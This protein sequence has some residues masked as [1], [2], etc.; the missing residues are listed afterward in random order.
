MLAI[1]TQLCV[2]AVNI[3]QAN[4]GPDVWLQLLEYCATDPD[5]QPTALRS[6]AQQLAEQRAFSAQRLAKQRVVNT[7]LQ[8]QVLD[9]QQHIAGLQKQMQELHAVVHQLLP[10]CQQ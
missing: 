8:R 1:V 6:L 2:F 5:C 7:R 9:Q 3:L 10:P 4:T